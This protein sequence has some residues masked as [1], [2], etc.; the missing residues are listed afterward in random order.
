MNQYD[1]AYQRYCTAYDALHD[2][3]VYHGGF[4]AITT[5]YRAALEALKT[6]ELNFCPIDYQQRV[7]H[8]ADVD[9]I[10]ADSIN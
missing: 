4:L 9:K 10:I 1:K 6:E 8:L 7:G 5:E 3:G 2:Q